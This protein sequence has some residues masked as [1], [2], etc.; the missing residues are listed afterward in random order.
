M[1]DMGRSTGP[2][3]EFEDATVSLSG[4]SVTQFWAGAEL[5]PVFL[6]CLIDF[7]AKITLDPSLLDP[8]VLDLN[9]SGY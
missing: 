3:T 7:S 4:S 9:I 6:H 1:E 5:F 8:G 2:F